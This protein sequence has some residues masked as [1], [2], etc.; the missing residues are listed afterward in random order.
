MAKMIQKYLDGQGAEYLTEEAADR[1]DARRAAEEVLQPVCMEIGRPDLTQIE[2]FNANAL[3]PL[4]DYICKL[5][6]ESDERTR[7][8]G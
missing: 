2:G 6:R 8:F 1:A 7:K 3:R 4:H 5:M